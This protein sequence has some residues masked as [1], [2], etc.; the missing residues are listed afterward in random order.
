MFTWPAVPTKRKRG[1]G[2]GG[3]IDSNFSPVPSFPLL[4]PFSFTPLYSRDNVVASLAASPSPPSPSFFFVRLIFSSGRSKTKLRHPSCKRSEKSVLN[5]LES[6]KSTKLSLKCT[7]A[8]RF[9]HK[10]TFKK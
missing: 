3:C 6:N 5:I 8:V 7:V 1:E 4:P 9:P 10:K 2:R